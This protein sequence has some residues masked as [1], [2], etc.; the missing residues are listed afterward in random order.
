MSQNETPAQRMPPNQNRQPGTQPSVVAARRALQYIEMTDP[1]YAVWAARFEAQR[2]HGG[3]I[4]RGP[5]PR[6]A[7]WMEFHVVDMVYKSTRP[8]SVPAHQTWD[9]PV[10]PMICTCTITHPGA[11]QGQPGCGAYWNL[12]VGIDAS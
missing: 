5:C 9:D 3:T 6:C 11:P 10:V 4:L 2:M 7:D 12:R 1:E 8:P